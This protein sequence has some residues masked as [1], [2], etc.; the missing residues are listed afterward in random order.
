[1]SMASEKF[2]VLYG[3]FQQ[4]YELRKGTDTRSK[5]LDLLKREKQYLK[6]YMERG[7]TRDDPLPYAVRNILSHVGKNPQQ[8]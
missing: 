4:K 5:M 6:P 2:F 3:K 7:K 1:M 8:T